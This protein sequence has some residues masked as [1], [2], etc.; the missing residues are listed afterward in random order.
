MRNK[1]EELVQWLNT[2]PEKSERDWLI[3]A[4]C[5]DEAQRNELKCLF[6]RL[7][8]MNIPVRV[9]HCCG[10]FTDDANIYR[11]AVE[12]DPEWADICADLEDEENRKP[13]HHSKK[14]VCDFMIENHCYDLDAPDEV[15]ETPEPN[16]YLYWKCSQIGIEPLRAH[17][18]YEIYESLKNYGGANIPHWKNLYK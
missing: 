16:V 3:E 6:S 7:D 2:N 14:I 17:T 8:E 10:Y 15:F 13:I 5:I 11:T 9:C 12:P 18:E 1:R 4:R